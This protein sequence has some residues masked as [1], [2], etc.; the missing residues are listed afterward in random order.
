MSLYLAP[1]IVHD[2]VGIVI[3]LESD[4]GIIG[5]TS[6]IVVIVVLVEVVIVVLV[7]T[8]RAKMLHRLLHRSRDVENV[9]CL[10][11]QSPRSLVNSFDAFPAVYPVSKAFANVASRHEFLAPVALDKVVM[12]AI[13]TK[14]LSHGDVSMS[15]VDAR[16]QQRVVLLGTSVTLCPGDA[17]MYFVVTLRANV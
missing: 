3:F 8:R 5:H 9:T 11:L 15:R 17:W 13:G 2:R 10:A 14:V 16:R 12:E 7:A 1:R 4:G 6:I